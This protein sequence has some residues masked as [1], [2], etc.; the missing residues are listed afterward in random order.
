VR[1]EELLPAG[2]IICGQ[3][4]DSVR[5]RRCLMTADEHCDEKHRQ[6]LRD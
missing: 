5:R 6:R 3:L 1:Y 4:R 2:K